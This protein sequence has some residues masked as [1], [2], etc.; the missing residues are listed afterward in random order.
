MAKIKGLKTASES[1]VTTPTPSSFTSSYN[2]LAKTA[3]TPSVKQADT[4]ASFPAIIMPG[5]TPSPNPFPIQPIQKAQKPKQADSEDIEPEK[6]DKKLSQKEEEEAEF[7]Y[8]N[9]VE[10]RQRKLVEKHQKAKKKEEEGADDKDDDDD[11]KV[12]AQATS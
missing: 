3:S 6:Q 7:D 1:S 9:D 2:S 8:M 4:A 12:S 5:P 10:A 11:K